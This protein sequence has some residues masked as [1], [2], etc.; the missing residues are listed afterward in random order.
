[1]NRDEHSVRRL[2]S[3]SFKLGKT[4]DA[5]AFM[6]VARYVGIEIDPISVFP[7]V[8]FPSG[9]FF[10]DAVLSESIAEDP[11]RRR[12]P[13]DPTVGELMDKSRVAEDAALSA[14]DRS[15]TESRLRVRVEALEFRALTLLDHVNATN[16]AK[17]LVSI[18]K[19]DARNSKRRE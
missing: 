7:S 4:A 11:N 9:A 18:A 10:V 15:D 16:L 8:P 2:I 1:M 6:R 3:L 17:L 13:K 5:F 19:G 14:I 12:F